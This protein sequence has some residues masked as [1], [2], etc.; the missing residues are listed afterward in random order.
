MENKE[1]NN[2]ESIMTP[3]VYKKTFWR[4]FPLQACFC[5]ERMQNVGFAYMMIPAL[6]KL[7]KD[8][9]DI[10]E[11]L[12][13]H[14]VI[15]NTTPAIVSFI[16]GAAIAMEEKFKKAKDNGEEVDEESI[17]A[18]KAALMGPLAGIGDSLVVGTVIP[19]LLGVAMGMSSGGSPLGAIFYIIV[20]NLFAYFG[21]KFLY[22]K[23]YEL[24]G[25]AVEFLVGSQGEALRESITM[26]GGIVIGAVAA[27]WVNVQTSFTMIAKGAEKPYLDLQNTLN[28]VYPGFLTAAFVLLCWYL[29]SKRKMSPIKVMLLLVIIAF[30][31]VLVGFFNPGLAY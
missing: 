17:N 20:W 18:V 4:T 22:F 28:S 1:I 29:L 10:S 21:M 15:F 3:D 25:K 7:Y 30:V 26:L 6:K 27:T 23:G 14:L 13:R 16:A 11:A 12:K 5:Y 9:K 31:G 24:G 2:Q 8:K 19:I